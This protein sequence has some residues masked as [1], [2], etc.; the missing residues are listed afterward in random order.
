MAAKR[1]TRAREAQL[2][3]EALAIEGGL[4]SP[5]WLSKVAQLQAGTQAE[6]DYRIHKGLNLRDEIGRYWRIAQ[7]HWADFKSGCEAKADPK[8]KRHQQ[9]EWPPARPKTTEWRRHAVT[10]DC[11]HRTRAAYDEDVIP[12]SPFGPRLMSVIALLTGVY[13]LSRRKTVTVLSELLGVRISLGAV[14]AVEADV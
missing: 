12:S 13:H 14:S 2:A 8:A 3:F 6:A 5:E 4:L 9:S 10:C 1:K 7:A 11:G